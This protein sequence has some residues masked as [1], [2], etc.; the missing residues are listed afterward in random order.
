MTQDDQDT[1]D[2]VAVL[3]IV[4]GAYIVNALL[5]RWVVG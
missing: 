2:L 5:L 3:A 1:R 4:T